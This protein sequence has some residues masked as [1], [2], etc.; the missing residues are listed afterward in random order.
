MLQKKLSSKFG[1]PNAASKAT[2]TPEDTCVP[3]S[4]ATRP[5]I[6]THEKH[7]EGVNTEYS[8][9][10]RGLHG[11][12]SKAKPRIQPQNIKQQASEAVDDYINRILT[13][14]AD[15]KVPEAILVGMTR[16]CRYCNASG[17]KDTSTVFGG[18]NNSG[19]NSTNDYSKTQRK[20]NRT[21]SQHS[22][23]YL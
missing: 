2:A 20:F 10:E 15:S 23:I 3:A 18:S 11:K 14:T 19:E 13:Q 21:G 12:V 16:S 6:K 1:T 22:Q 8:L 17:P 4:T 9:T 5:W 7:Y